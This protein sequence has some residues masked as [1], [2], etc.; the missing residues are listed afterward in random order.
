MAKIYLNESQ[1]REMIKDIILEYNGHMNNDQ[2]FTQHQAL[3]TNPNIYDMYNYNAQQS[4]LDAYAQAT[5]RQAAQRQAAQQAAQQQQAAQRQQMGQQFQ[6]QQNQ[7]NQQQNQ[8]NN[9]QNGMTAANNSRVKQPAA[10][11]NQ[12]TMTGKHAEM[13]LQAIIR[14]QKLW[15]QTQQET[16]KF[17]TLFQNYPTPGA[18]WLRNLYQLGNKYNNPQITE[19]ADN[20]RLI[21]NG[22]KVPSQKVN[23]N[24]NQG[25]PIYGNYPVSRQQSGPQATIPQSGPQATRQQSGPQA[26]Q[27]LHPYFQQQLQNRSNYPTNM[28]PRK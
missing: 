11:P 6:Q 5:Q 24:A 10:A 13:Q 21:I 26:T 16:Y 27:P 2:M 14:G 17:V 1:L 22:K 4:V 3:G 25:K 8:W 15:P 18:G 9:F 19:L 7:F 23:Q 12:N 20:C 28:Y